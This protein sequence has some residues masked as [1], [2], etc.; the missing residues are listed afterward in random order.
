MPIRQQFTEDDGRMS[1]KR[2]FVCRGCRWKLFLAAIVGGFVGAGA[3][4]LGSLLF[5]AGTDPWVAECEAMLEDEMDSGR[6]RS[7]HTDSSVCVAIV[8]PELPDRDLIRRDALGSWIDTY[9]TVL[10]THY[11]ALRAA[12]DGGEVRVRFQVDAGGTPVDLDI[13]ESSG[14]TAVEAFAFDLA[15]TMS[16]SPAVNGDAATDSWAEYSVAVGV[17]AQE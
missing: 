16:F 15:T 12:G 17:R 5:T 10:D 1:E 9:R 6:D 8:Y 2:G 13:A 11:A 14:N 4:D 7:Y 3:D